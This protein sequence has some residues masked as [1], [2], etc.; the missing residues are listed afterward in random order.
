MSPNAAVGAPPGDNAPA[1]DPVA[2]SGIATKDVVVVTTDRV[3]RTCHDALKIHYARH[4]D[5]A[6]V[7]VAG[8]VTPHDIV[9]VAPYGVAAVVRAAELRTDPGLLRSV[10][11]LA[12]DGG[13]R[14]PSGV[15]SRLRTAAAGS[16]RQVLGRP[17]ILLKPAEVD[18]VVLVAEGLTRAGIAG[19]LGQGAEHVRYTLKNA[20]E[21]LGVERP[22][23]AV[24]YAAREGLLWELPDQEA[25]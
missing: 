22:A 13:H 2:R 25:R 17:G 8:R 11:A 4:P 23:A 20:L 3:D 24:A 10:K 12:A 6:V 19:R 7:L 5:A 18:V 16:V 9:A 15:G 1:T 21:R 14:L